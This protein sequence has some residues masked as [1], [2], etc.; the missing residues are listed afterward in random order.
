[1]MRRLL[2]AAPLLLGLAACQAPVTDSGSLTQVVFFNEDSAALDAPATE[3]LR[4]A[5]ATARANPQAPVAVLGFAG[6]VGSQAYNEAL[7]D[8]RARHV[9]DQLV[10]FGVAP[11]RISIRPRGPVP[12]E[13]MPT[14]SRRV[15]IR[16]GG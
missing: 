5:A 16:I 2:L 15:E 11:A 14:E 6:P 4:G 1:M 3:V 7:S 13:S 9:A 8:A 12:Y 10:A